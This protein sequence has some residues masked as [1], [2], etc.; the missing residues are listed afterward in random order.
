M[1]C[2]S[3]WILCTGFKAASFQFWLVHFEQYVLMFW[4]VDVGTVH[5]LCVHVLYLIYTYFVTWTVSIDQVVI[6]LCQLLLFQCSWNRW[7][8][9]NVLWRQ[10]S[11][12]DGI[13]WFDLER[14]GCMF[15][16][17][18][19][20]IVLWQVFYNMARKQEYLTKKN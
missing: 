8:Y 15:H 3:N 7:N 9:G 1:V 18:E 4:V 20:L 2:S 16:K 5:R 10:S 17:E 13:R 12:F 6:L 11:Y 14:F 19:A